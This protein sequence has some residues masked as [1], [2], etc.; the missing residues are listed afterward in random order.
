MIQPTC[1][2]R[3]IAAA[4]P[5]LAFLAAGCAA[6][7]VTGPGPDT[8]AITLSIVSTNDVHG[9]IVPRDGRGG[10]PLLG[11]YLRNLRA[12]RARDGGAVLL[13]DAGDMWQGTL[14][15]NLTEGA[16]VVAAYNALGY[17]AAAVGN[18]EFDYGPIGPETTA[19][20]GGD[21]P[22]GALKA[23]AR[24][25]RF[26][27]LAANLLDASTGAPVKWPNVVPSLMTNAAG[28]QIG[29]VGVMTREAL[30]TTIAA[31]VQELAVA[32]LAA[33]IAAEARSLKAKGASVIVVAAHAGG[34][35]T[36]FDEPTDLTS[37]ETASEIFEVAR[38][39][40]PRLVDVILAGHAHGGV[41]HEVNGIA[42]TSAFSGGRA[43][44]RIDVQV[45]RRSGAVMGRRIFAPRDLCNRQNARTGRCDPAD[46]DRAESPASYEG[47]PVRPDRAIQRILASAVREAEKV[48]TASVGVL[49][50]TPLPRGDAPESALGNLFT[51]AMREATGAD[52]SLL[53]VR[54]GLRADLPAGPLTY[55]SLYEALP[56]DN[57]LVRLRLTAAGLKRVLIAQLQ[58]KTIAIGFSGIHVEAACAGDAVAVKLR[59]A[60]GQPIADDVELTI[61]TSDFLATGGDA[62]LSPVMPPLG[63]AP[64]DDELMLRD[65]VAD[66]LRARGG[67]VRAGDLVDARRPRWTLPGT[68]PLHCAS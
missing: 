32:P 53:N 47:A 4:V 40:P 38:Q 14:E 35:C 25:A 8:A 56:F 48:K 13:V 57:R 31:N 7:R 63:F 39:L 42:I 67:R 66:W 36:E 5:S 17:A 20:S 16:P 65:V 27:F 59:D 41:A 10:L 55:G 44:G 3:L 51:D 9:G 52:V 19:K 21:D 50:E 18:H 54:G 68:L 61:I 62:I 45:H 28:I 58:A 12:A 49:L 11:G 23:R 34:R 64:A 37:C 43:F 6:Q 15:S 2:R 1:A 33:T 24:E 26:P 46:P 30:T 29:I 60:S 22:R